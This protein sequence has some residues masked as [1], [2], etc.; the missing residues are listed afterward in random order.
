MSQENPM[1]KKIIDRFWDVYWYI[2]WDEFE[3][4]KAAYL[5]ILQQTKKTTRGLPTPHLDVR[6]SVRVEIYQVEIYQ[7]SPDCLAMVSEHKV[8]FWPATLI[9]GLPFLEPK[10]NKGLYIYSPATGSKFN[11]LEIADTLSQQLAKIQLG[12]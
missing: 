1:R 11:N 5:E 8:S 12:K 10:I 9:R 2:F 4:Q 6:K 3:K 7:F